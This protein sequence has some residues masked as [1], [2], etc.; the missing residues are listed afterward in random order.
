MFNEEGS[1][2]ITGQFFRSHKLPQSSFLSI[3]GTGGEVG[4]WGGALLSAKTAYCTAQCAKEQHEQMKLILE[5][6]R[7]GSARYKY[8][9][10]GKVE[11][12]MGLS[13]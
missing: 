3:P 10:K 9:D 5:S 1:A 8:T 7:T 6:H 13:I 12:H 11:N 4:E 2:Q